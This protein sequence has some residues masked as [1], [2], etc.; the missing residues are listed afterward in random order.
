MET[1]TA[2]PS[3]LLG[4]ARYGARVRS[5][6]SLV[7]TGA[8]GFIGSALARQLLAT[9]GV[10]KV[11]ALDCLPEEQGLRSLGDLCTDAR[12]GYLSADIRD[13]SLVA[14]LLAELQTTG[15]FNLADQRGGPGALESNILGTATLLEVC[16]DLH[17]PLLQASTDAVYGNIPSPQRAT[18]DWATLPSNSHAATKAAA[19][20]LCLAA[21]RESG[22]DV[23]V[24]RAATTYGPRLPANHRL[25]GFIR[26]AVHDE[27]LILPGDGMQIRDWL[28]LDDHCAGLIEAFRRAKRG[29]AFNLAGKCERTFLGIARSVLKVLGKPESLAQ[30]GPEV[31]G[32]DARR[33]TDA[34]K[35]ARYTGWYPQLE[36]RHTFTPVVREAAANLA[37]A[38]EL[39]P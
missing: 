35:V 3:F 14:N 5:L 23:I 12:F 25:T 16:R 4:P 2:T 29:E 17:I 32:V 9:E 10:E 21:A 19:D 1:Q 38:S 24:T 30:P 26:A 20:L 11:I 39:A 13:Q 15:V 33:A 18:E 22:Q 28:H 31:P 34:T 6:R 7:V 27:P 36:F 37:Q 8:A